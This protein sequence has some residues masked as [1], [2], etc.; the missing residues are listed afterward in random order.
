MQHIYSDEKS[1]YE[2]KEKNKGIDICLNNK[3][4]M[5]QCYTIVH[6]YED[7]VYIAILQTF[8]NIMPQ[9]FDE[10]LDRTSH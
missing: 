9:L 3:L 10:K 5:M 1:I 8:E 4:N 2:R 7:Y 6:Y